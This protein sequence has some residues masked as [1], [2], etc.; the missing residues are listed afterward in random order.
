MV[1]RFNRIWLLTDSCGDLRN[2]LGSL[3][4]AGNLAVVNHQTVGY[5][6]VYAK[7]GYPLTQATVASPVMS[8]E[9]PE[10]VIYL[11]FARPVPRVRIVTAPPRSP[12][13][14]E[15]GLHSSENRWKA[16]QFPNFC[17]QTGPEK[18]SH[19]RSQAILLAFF[20]EG[21]TCSPVSTIPLGE[22]NAIRNR[23]FDE[24]LSTLWCLGSQ[25]LSRLLR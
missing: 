24:R 10:E 11:P 4:N 22:C 2:A 17:F 13:C 20:S 25:T 8:L 16:P 5:L 14:R 23:C 9:N 15:A 21:T 18:M 19:C 12:G 6:H 7:I 3:P 1:P